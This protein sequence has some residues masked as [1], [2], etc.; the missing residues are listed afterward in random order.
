MDFLEDIRKQWEESEVSSVIIRNVI[1]QLEKKG[2]TDKEFLTKIQKHGPPFTDYALDVVRY[3]VGLI[4]GKDTGKEIML[5]MEEMVGN[6][7]NRD[8]L[9][10]LNKEIGKAIPSAV[11][12]GT[13]PRRRHYSS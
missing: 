7:F 5:K 10:D 1:G 13:R 2:I 4:S 11:S 6:G 8:L 3:R 9:M 12:L